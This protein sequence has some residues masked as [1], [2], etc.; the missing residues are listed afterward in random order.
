MFLAE[1]FLTGFRM[2]KI[3]WRES[4][5]SQWLKIYAYFDKNLALVLIVVFYSDW[6]KFCCYILIIYDTNF[7]FQCVSEYGLFDNCMFIY[8]ISSDE[9]T[10]IEANNGWLVFACA[11]TKVDLLFKHESCS[12]GWKRTL[13]LLYIMNI[14]MWL[15]TV[16]LLLLQFEASYC[17]IYMEILTTLLLDLWLYNLW[18]IS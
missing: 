4:I 1:F 6:F 12:I 17:D 13:Y 5:W 18:Q 8:L 10:S 15:L 9:P 7:N 11:Q 14:F 2:I 3:W 16:C